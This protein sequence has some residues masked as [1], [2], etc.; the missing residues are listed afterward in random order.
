MARTLRNGNAASKCMKSQGQ[1]P[2]VG[3]WREQM[4]GKNQDDKKQVLQRPRSRRQN[5]VQV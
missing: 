3:V 1:I 5:E 4:T 2:N